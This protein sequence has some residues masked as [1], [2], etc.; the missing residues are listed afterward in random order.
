MTIETIETVKAVK[1]D[2]NINWK[3]YRTYL[4]TRFVY[5]LPL[6]HIMRTYDIID[7]SDF[8]CIVY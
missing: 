8:M 2:C 7:T 4:S 1:A 3:L 5:V 6:H